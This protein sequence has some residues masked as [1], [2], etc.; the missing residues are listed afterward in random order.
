MKGPAAVV[1]LTVALAGCGY[2]LAGRGNALPDHIRR[3]GV[4]TFE[5]QSDTPNLERILTDAVRQELQSRGRYTIVQETTGVD[6]V[7]TGTVRPVLLTVAALTSG[8]QAQQYVITVQATV[9]FKDVKEAKV[10][11]S[12]PN[13]RASDEYEPAGATAVTDAAAIFSQDQNA[14]NRLARAFARSLV[15]SIL[16]A[17]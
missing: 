9:E 17:F 4:P 10:L 11:W 12:N 14:L 15:A 7:L 1:L 8:R 5:N 3:I 16:E 13:M 2:A 6:A